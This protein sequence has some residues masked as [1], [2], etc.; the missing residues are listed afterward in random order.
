MTIH[1]PDWMVW[2]LWLIAGGCGIVVLYILY[3][4]VYIYGA[5]KGRWKIPDGDLP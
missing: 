5:S 2:I 1:I 3:I 4:F